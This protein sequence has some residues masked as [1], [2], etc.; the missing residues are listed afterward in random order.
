MCFKLPFFF[1]PFQHLIRRA[2]NGSVTDLE[3]VET[4]QRFPSW[5]TQDPSKTSLTCSFR[6]ARP[7]A[8]RFLIWNPSETD[9]SASL[10]KVDFGRLVLFIR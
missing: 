1:Y 4:K 3:N 10:Q 5:E 7:L 9:S 6:S 2:V 8:L